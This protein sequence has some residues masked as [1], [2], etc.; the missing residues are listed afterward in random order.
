MNRGP[1]PPPPEKPPSV[2][3]RTRLLKSSFRKDDIDKPK[4]ADKSSTLLSGEKVGVNV[5]VNVANL[6]SSS[7]SRVVTNGERSPSP[8]TIPSVQHQGANNS[9]STINSG[10]SGGVPVRPL[11]QP[12]PVLDNKSLNGNSLLMDN[13]KDHSKSGVSIFLLFKGILPTFFFVLF[14][15]VGEW[16]SIILGT[17]RDLFSL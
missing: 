1:A 8:T 14:V 4:I 11:V 15:E 9:N 3:E 17:F 5:S 12:P 10:V 2:A 16:I 6:T 7:S 13:N